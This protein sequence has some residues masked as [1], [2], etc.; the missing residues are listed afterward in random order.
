MARLP[1]TTFRKEI[2]VRVVYGQSI[3]DLYYQI[4]RIL[5]RESKEFEFFFAE[6][7]VNSVRGE[8]GWN[9]KAVGL[10]KSCRDFT[11]HDW[12]SVNNKLLSYSE[13]LK[14]LI[15]KLESKGKNNSSGAE[16]LR[17]MLM[18]PDLKDSL[19]L[20]GNTLV[21]TQWGC[22]KYGTDSKS[23]DLFEQIHKV[24]NSFKAH[25]TN[26]EP[27]LENIDNYEAEHINEKHLERKAVDINSLSNVEVLEKQDSVD[28]KSTQNII[29]EEY[30]QSPDEEFLGQ[31]KTNYLWRWLV[32]LI[33]FLLLLL[34]IAIK[35]FHQ[36]NSLEIEKILR[37]EIT[38]LWADV[39]KK[40]FE[41]SANIESSSL[42]V[43]NDKNTISDLEIK[44]RQIQNNIDTKKSVNVSLAW[45]NKADLD[46]FILQPD[47]NFSSY[48]PC[49]SNSCGHLD[50]DANRCDAD[51][52]NCT[53]VVARPLENI[54]W[55]DKMISGNYIVMVGM[56][57]TNQNKSTLPIIPFTVQVT[58]NGIMKSYQGQINPEDIK[59]GHVCGMMPRKLT[60]FTIE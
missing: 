31:P 50:V 15:K 19:F 23:A 51:S 12:Q 52:T 11:D 1:L 29:S 48:M 24:P 35:Y 36:N 14:K 28:R 42:A 33:L 45:N 39:D 22:Y 10:I 53:S 25:H 49:S 13:Q 46:L 56:Y 43:P 54:S 32:L 38:S 6:P 47:G 37:S 7:I 8:I 26:P 60:E 44:N 9:T 21:L 57:S 41:C 20:V 59:C 3:F 4:Q 16:A 58:I 27:S 30:L 55:Q 18:T 17:N 2:E 34:G 5:N 40:T